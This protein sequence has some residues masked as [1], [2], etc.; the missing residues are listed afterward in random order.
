MSELQVIES[1]KLLG[2]QFKIFGSVE[3][4]LFLA[5]DVAEWIEYDL[6]SV[7]KLVDLVDTNEKVRKTAPTPGGNQEAWFLTEDG[8]YEV[9]MQSRKPIAKEFKRQVKQVLKDI[10]KHGTYMT[11]ETIERTLT[12]PDF[13]IKLATTLKEEKEARLIAEHKIKELSPKAEFY[14]TVT[15]SKDCIDIGQAAKV[16]NFG[17]GRTTLFKI[18][19]E[20]K[21]LMYDN[22]PYQTYIDR[23]YFRVVESKFTKPNGDTC[24]SKKTVVYQRGLDFIRRFLIKNG[25]M[26]ETA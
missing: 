12:D 4:P 16:L 10:R 26:K 23:G 3:E 13:I 8:L 1:R 17:K 25:H 21:I 15:G 14:D 18:L 24:I 9:L 11:P 5:K 19:R 22:I 7:N 2:R 20:H 6:S